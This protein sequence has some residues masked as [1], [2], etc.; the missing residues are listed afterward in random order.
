MCVCVCFLLLVRGS[1]GEVVVVVRVVVVVM[2]G[3]CA[4]TQ[5]VRVFVSSIVG[6]EI[7]IGLHDS[8]HFHVF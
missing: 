1:C 7:H 2:L 8:E 5:D 3:F 4:G 6:I